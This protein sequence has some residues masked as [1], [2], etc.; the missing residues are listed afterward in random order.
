MASALVIAVM[1]VV[2]V[3]VAVVGSAEVERGRQR[4]RDVATDRGR[5][6]RALLKLRRGLFGSIEQ[7][8]PHLKI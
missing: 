2:V 5:F 4:H 6:I 1:V 7:N 3:G 8:L